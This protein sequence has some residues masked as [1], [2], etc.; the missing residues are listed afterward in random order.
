MGPTCAGSGAECLLPDSNH[1]AYW[2]WSVAYEGTS[3]SGNILNV[4]SA[5]ISQNRTRHAKAL[6]TDKP[7]GEPV[8]VHVA[9][10]DSAEAAYIAR[11]V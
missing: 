7:G 9:P 10:T 4:A 6:W 1:G 11:E 2:Y 8:R 5:L 3:C